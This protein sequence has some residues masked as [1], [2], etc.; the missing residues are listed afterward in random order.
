MFD[1]FEAFA[2]FTSS[3]FWKQLRAAVEETW[4]KEQEVQR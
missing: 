4:Q 3:D 2:Q 1:V